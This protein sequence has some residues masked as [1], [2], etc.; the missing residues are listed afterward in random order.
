MLGKIR[1]A[2]CFTA[3]LMGFVAAAAVVPYV[4]N[5]DPAGDAA[6]FSSLTIPAG[7]VVVFDHMQFTSQTITI[8]LRYTTAASGIDNVTGLWDIVIT[9]PAPGK[10]C[11]TP[12][13]IRLYAGWIVTNVSAT[14]VYLSGLAMDDDDLYAGVGNEIDSLNLAGGTLLGG[15]QLDSPRPVVATVEQS[16]DMKTWTEDSGASVQK[17][18]APAQLEF[19][20][21]PDDRGAAFRVKARS[22]R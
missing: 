19:T 8:R 15:I 5:L 4:K 14:K 22:V 10:L 18:A 3:L 13:P 1:I 9:N 7:K 12:A 11:A 2:A 6:A 17:G 16:E 21:T 20:T